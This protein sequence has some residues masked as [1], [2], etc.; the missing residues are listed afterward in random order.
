MKAEDELTKN[1]REKDSEL[2]AGFMPQI[3]NADGTP[4]KLC[5]VIP[6]KNCK[7]TESNCDY[8]WQKVNLKKHSRGKFPWFDNA[9]IGKNP[10]STYMSD[11]SE[12]I[13]L[14]EQYTNDSIHVTGVTNLTHGHYTPHQI[15]SISGH[16]SI[17]SLSIHQRVKKDEKMMMGMSLM[18]SL[19]QPSDVAKVT[20]EC[21]PVFEI[22]SNPDMMSH[23]MPMLPQPQCAQ[24][25]VQQKTP[26]SA[27]QPQETALPQISEQAIVPYLSLQEDESRKEK[28]GFD[29]LELLS[30]DADTD[31]MLAATQ[32]ENQISHFSTMT[33]MSTTSIVKK[34]LQTDLHRQLVQTLVDGSLETLGH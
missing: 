19:L 14:D 13:G 30:D 6:Y 12:L 23:P 10:H 8:L 22:K 5:P 15:M 18:Y 2:V 26:L 25:N 1:H 28:Q 16:K 33:T 27:I 3:L 34:L 9:R 29:I 7:W 32:I 21:A 17:Q 20:R 4:H 31:L 11:L 24:L